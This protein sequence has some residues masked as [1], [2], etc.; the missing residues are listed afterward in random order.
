MRST[1]IVGRHLRST[2]RNGEVGLLAG[3]LQRNDARA[4]SIDRIL[5][6]RANVDDVGARATDDGVFAGARI[7]V[8]ARRAASGRPGGSL[9]ENGVGTQSTGDGSAPSVA[10]IHIV[11]T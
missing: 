8:H 3:D 9:G 6:A 7:D 1:R 11:V 4:A 2:D 10:E 5:A